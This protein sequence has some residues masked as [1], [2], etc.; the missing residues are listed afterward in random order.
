MNER[1]RGGERGREKRKKKEI[2]KEGRKSSR[3]EKI[4]KIKKKHKQGSYFITL[5][6]S[7]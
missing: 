3:K 4:N 1:C 7:S 5:A 6:S 2:E